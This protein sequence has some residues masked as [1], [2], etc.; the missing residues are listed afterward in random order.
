[1]EENLIDVHLSVEIKEEAMVAHLYFKNNSNKK[2]HLHKQTI[3]YNG[4][5]RNNYFEIYNKDEEEMD[6]LGVMKNCTLRPEDFV[7]LAPGEKL[8]STIQLNDYYK[9]YKGDIYNVRYYAFNPSFLNQQQLMHMESN[10]VEIT[11]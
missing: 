1:M 11:Y 8:N 2:V 7:E 4:E 9:I 3:Y 6:Y 5:V 10:K